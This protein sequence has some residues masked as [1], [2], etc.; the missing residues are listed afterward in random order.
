MYLTRE[1]TDNSLPKIDVNL[2]GK[3]PYN[4]NSCPWKIKSMLEEDDNLRLEIESIKI[5]RI[6]VDKFL[7]IWKLTTNCAQVRIQSTIEL[8]FHIIHIAYYYY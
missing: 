7:K 1:L 4:C 8:F 5:N 2:A 3:R 6:V